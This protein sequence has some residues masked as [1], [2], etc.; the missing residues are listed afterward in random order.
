MLIRKIIFVFT[1]IFLSVTGVCQNGQIIGYIGDEQN[2]SPLNGVTVN[3]TGSRMI[4]E[5]SDHFGT[6]KIHDL[7]PGHYE[8]MLSHVGYL[9]EKIAIDL[10]QNKIAVV[11]VAMQKSNVTLSDVTVVTR[12]P[13][14]LNTLAAVDIKLRPINTSQ[15]ILRLVSGLFIAQ[16]AG[17]GKAEQ[18]FLRGY[19]IDH[20]TDI[21]ISVDGL[22]VNMVSHAHGQGYA[23]LHFLIP[24]TVEKINFDKGPYYTNKGNLATAGFVEMQ[25]KD[26]LQENLV[27]IQAGKFNSQ[28]VLGMVKLLNKSND[29]VRQQLYVASEYFKS[30]GYFDSPQK[31]HRFN[32]MGKYNAIFNNDAQLTIL[33]STLDSR[34]N[35]SGQI[36]DRAVESGM[37]GRFGSIDNSEGGNTNRTNISAKFTKR[38]HDGWQT[39]DQLYFTNYHFNLFS[40]F[41]FFLK[42]SINGDEINQRETRNIYGYTGTM[43]KDYFIGRK[44]AH[45]EFGWGARFDDVN[46]IALNHVVRRQFL[47]HEQS[48]DVREWN[49][50]AYVQQHVK[51]NNH[52]N[53]NG[54]LR[55]DYFRFAYKN[56]LAGANSFAIQSRGI[57]SPKLNFNYNINSAVRVYL[58]TGIGFHSNDTRVILNNTA[59]DILPKV[60]GT[61]LGV[62][63]KPAKQLLVKA[64]LW[65]LHS[66]QEFVYVGDEGIVEPGGKTRRSGVDLSARYQFNKWLYADVDLNYARPRTVDAPKGEDYVPLAPT[67]TSIGGLTV[68]SNGF[69]AGVRYRYIGDRP[70]NEDN[71]VRA[72]GYFLMDAV[73]SYAFKKFE[74]GISA[75]NL[76]NRYWKEAQFDTESRLQTEIIPVSEI[77]YTP[78]TP[79][80]IKAGISYIF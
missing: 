66:Q 63:L 75:E 17:G 61:D 12:K 25:T 64:A 19:D 18:I 57:V 58:N 32:I 60:F 50:F 2:Q 7:T 59:K 45:T 72:Q 65:Q 4:A 80:F 73:L 79:R 10:E 28:R 68:K 33:A 43:S 54:G 14:A 55:Y 9:T 31:F 29:R 22:P 48:G 27:K 37:I 21:N 70:A 38:W 34:W 3:I 42:D 71:T 26:F 11:K 41:T 35:A 62:V 56:I 5:N 15:D 47:S 51:L 30:D 46:N 44:S 24:E 49:G 6:F 39:T 69:N 74:I 76:L 40:N 52:F 67:F 78:G 13:S 1:C 36:P 23:D 8:I 16:H 77:H 20:G 53:I